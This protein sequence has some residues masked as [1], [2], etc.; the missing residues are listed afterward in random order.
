MV[1]PEAPRG[2]DRFRRDFVGSVYDPV[3]WTVASARGRRP[4]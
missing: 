1:D 3:R 4:Q 2:S